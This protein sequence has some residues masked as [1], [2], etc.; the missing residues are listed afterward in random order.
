MRTVASAFLLGVV[1]A[2]AGNGDSQVTT[3]L[4]PLVPTAGSSASQSSVDSS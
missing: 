1:M 4:P 2:C 3:N